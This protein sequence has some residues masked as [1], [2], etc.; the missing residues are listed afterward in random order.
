MKIFCTIAVLTFSCLLPGVAEVDDAVPANP[1]PRWWKGNLH[2]HTLWSDGNG[3]P[4][5]VAEWYRV[6]GYNF[7]A[8]SDHNVLSQ[9]MR[10]MPLT[11]IE[12]RAGEDA[13]DGYIDRFGEH[14]VEMK[15][16]ENGERHVRLKP[17]NEFRALLEDRG[18]FILMQGQ[19]IT[20][21]VGRVP[22]HINATNLAELIQP[23]HGEDF[24]ATMR[25]NLIAV[26]EQ[27]ARIG[28]PILPHLNHPNF[29]WAL[30]AEDIAAVTE[31]H[32]FEVFNGHTGV[33]NAGDALRADTERIWDVA[34]TIRL[35]QHS[36][37]PLFGLATD[38]SHSYHGRSDVSIPGRGWIM[39]RARHLTPESLLRAM[40]QGD[41]YASTG[42]VLRDVRFDA[43][44]NTLFVQI[45]PQPGEKYTIEFVG[46]REDP[47]LTSEEVRDAEGKEVRTTRRYSAE[48]GE[49]LLRVE[50]T[51]AEYTL[52]GNELYVRAVVTS[53]APPTHPTADSP[54][55]KAW[56]QPVGWRRLLDPGE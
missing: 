4:E 41:F 19:E 43:A 9:G 32:F 47:D 53:D 6:N 17:L 14:W 28:R 23:Q 27:A 45:D 29:G 56:T 26:A 35:V 51:S 20:D 22:I 50:G 36:A 52:A 46:T 54:L 38:D 12:R 8:L 21:S 15:A 40:E 44:S 30:T 55:K 16:V 31:E 48:I 5:M 1:E 42:V 33:H 13:L 18:V 37:P 10:W 2:T 11:E 7:L 25:N 49:V 39:V 3:F 24:Q 34:N